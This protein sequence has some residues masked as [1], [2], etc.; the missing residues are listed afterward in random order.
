MD[1]VVFLSEIV[2]EVG[3]EKNPQEVCATAD[4][5][6]DR[7]RKQVCVE[8]DCLI[9]PSGIVGTRTPV[10]WLP[11][12]QIVREGVPRDDAS[13]L[14]RE[15]FGSWVRKV[16]SSIPRKLGKSLAST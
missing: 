1:S 8:L 16:R 4:A 6:Y 10:D 13:E 15:I 12:K 2:A 7:Q 3:D 9:R 5:S 11:A 14:A